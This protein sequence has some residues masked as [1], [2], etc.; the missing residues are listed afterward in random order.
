MAD[1][2]RKKAS[3]DITVGDIKNASGTVNIAGGNI[4]VTTTISGL[5]MDEVARA[6]EAIYTRIETSQNTSA[7][8]KADLKA[9]VQDVQEAIKRPKKVDESF[10]TRRLRNIGRMAP[11]IMEV[12]LATIISPA[13][14]LGVIGKKIAE[15]LKEK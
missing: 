6:F 1:K 14:G 3:K 12:V 5:S 4:S 15:K 2:S 11:D 13:A 9:E 8:E 7:V 10:V